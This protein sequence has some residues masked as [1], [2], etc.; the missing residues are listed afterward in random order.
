MTTTKTENQKK[1]DLKKIEELLEKKHKLMF[2]KQEYQNKIKNVSKEI[3]HL[4]MQV[5]LDNVTKKVDWSN[6]RRPTG[7]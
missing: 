4:K 2:K 7:C 5:Y 3:H 6:T 1:R